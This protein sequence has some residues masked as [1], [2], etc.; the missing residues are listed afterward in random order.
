MLIL[1]LVVSPVV[2]GPVTWGVN[3]PLSGSILK[4][5]SLPVTALNWHWNVA[6]SNWSVKLPPNAVTELEVAETYK[7]ANKQ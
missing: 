5:G 2:V 1:T 3:L 6:V 4:V 7:C